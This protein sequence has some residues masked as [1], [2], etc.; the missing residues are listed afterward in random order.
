ML[1]AVFS[2]VFGFAT[3]DGGTVCYLETPSNWHPKLHDV[4]TCLSP[5]HLRTFFWAVAVVLSCLCH[6][7]C[8]R[9]FVLWPAKRGCH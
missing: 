2:K 8:F 5:E 7:A 4:S 3:G 9:G 1:V 6:Y